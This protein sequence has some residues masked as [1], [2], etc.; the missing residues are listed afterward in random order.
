MGNWITPFKSWAI[1]ADQAVFSGT[2]FLLTIILAHRLDPASFGVFSGLMLGLYLIV[3]LI[4][5]LVMQ[6]LQV[7]VSVNNNAHYLSFVFWAQTSLTLLTAILLFGLAT[8]LFPEFSISVS[9]LTF[10]IGFVFQDYL[11]KLFL[12]LNK[13][14]QSLFVDAITATGQIM[15]LTWLILN[16]KNELETIVFLLGLAYLPAILTGIIILKPFYF[17]ATL[18]KSFLTMHITQGGWLLISA[19]TQ[20]WAGNLFVVASGFYIGVQSLGALRLV[21]SLFGVLNV[22]LQTFENYVLPQTARLLFKSKNDAIQY[23]RSIVL[24]TSILI[25][26]ILLLLYVFSDQLIVLAGGQDYR[27]YGFLFRGMAI[28]Y[29]L[30]FVS[31]PIRIAIR[32]LILN[33]YFLYGYLISLLFALL[34]S[35]FLLSHYELLG[36]IAGLIGSQILLI[37]YWQFILHRKKFY[38]WKSF[39]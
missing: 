15:V 22:L 3:S 7:N 2:S 18:W 30:I 36:A 20:W 12:A 16:E 35:K 32:A 13:P 28:L 33:R 11:R 1:L 21:Q 23:L 6:P 31:Q 19:A 8:N 26:P 29:V 10:S 9:M 39:I 38:L 17:D 37:V 4:G 24:K 25:V 14:F 27:Q 34:S 5:A